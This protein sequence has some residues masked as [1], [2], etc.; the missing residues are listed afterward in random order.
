MSTDHKIFRT[1]NDPDTDH[2]TL[3][4]L[5]QSPDEVIRAAVAYNK[6]TPESVIETLLQD[7]S[8]H[9]RF[10]LRKRGILVN[11]MLTVCIAGKNNIAVDGL[12][13]LI[14]NYSKK[15]N[16]CFLPNPS[17]DGVDTWQRSF[18][19]FANEK[20]IPRTTLDEL[21]ELDSLI[22]ISLEFSEM[23]KTKKFKTDQL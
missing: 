14:E 8:N 7:P 21:Y 23:V 10:A 3:T 16:L 11:D 4:E 18:L 2:K 20:N 17:D 19:K 12:K 1:A 5:A 15:L 13:H 6:S 22:F 9:V